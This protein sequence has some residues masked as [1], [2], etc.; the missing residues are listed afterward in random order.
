MLS[1]TSSQTET[2]QN[3]PFQSDPYISDQQQESSSGHY[4]PLYFHGQESFERNPGQYAENYFYNQTH[5]LPHGMYH[6]PS[7]GTRI[8]PAATQAPPPGAYHQTPTA[9]FTR[10]VSFHSSGYSTEL[11]EQQLQVQN[12]YVPQNV[13]NRIH[14]V[15]TMP[16]IPAW[17]LEQ[18]QLQLLPQSMPP[19][20]GHLVH[21]GYESFHHSSSHH[22]VQT[23]VNLRYMQ[24]VS[25]PVY[26]R[27]PPSQQQHSHGTHSN[28]TPL[29]PS[30]TF[31]PPREEA[32]S[33]PLEQ[34]QQIGSSRHFEFHRPAVDPGSFTTLKSNHNKKPT[35]RNSITR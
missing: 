15:T 28:P 35:N 8:P 11:T 13:G 1:M 19:H 34:G 31:I 27:D 30:S 22:R 33:L 17:S 24:N 32:S 29:L 18:Q 5:N 2:W 7:A 9:S 14:G 6:I 25:S 26:C 4:D 16:S 20:P 3:Q 23:P 21:P 10:N 12:Q